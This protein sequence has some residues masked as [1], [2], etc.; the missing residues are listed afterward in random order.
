M[1][2]PFGGYQPQPIPQPSMSRMDL[3]PPASFSLHLFLTL[4]RR[5]VVKRI[6]ELVCFAQLQA[7]SFQ[8]DDSTPTDRELRRVKVDCAGVMPSMFVLSEY[9]A[10]CSAPAS[11]GPQ[12]SYFE[13]SSIAYFASLLSTGVY[14]FVPIED[15]DAWSTL[16]YRLFTTG[17]VKLDK[18]STIYASHDRTQ[19][20]TSTKATL[21]ETP[22]AVCCSAVKG[23][24]C[25][26]RSESAGTFGG[27]A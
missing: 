24:V 3:P 8:F 23:K 12:D 2:A 18:R 17:Q 20:N 14:C 22:H 5:L 21:D 26:D 15:W 7:S 16:V 19:G 10:A 6:F 4:R 13:S 11:S 1:H 27:S 9:R 25:W